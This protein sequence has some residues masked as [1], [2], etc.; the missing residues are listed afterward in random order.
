M[1]ARK[2]VRDFLLSKQ[3]LCRQLLISQQVSASTTRLPLFLAN[4]YRGSRQFSVFNEFSNQVKG[5]ANR[6]QEFQQSV[7][8]LKE[9]AEE[10]KG[11]KEDLKVRLGRHLQWRP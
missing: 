2:L 9:K 8:E 11:V 4:G 6:N 3:P 7:K 5:E 10:L 1:A